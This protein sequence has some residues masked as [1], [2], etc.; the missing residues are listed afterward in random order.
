MVKIFLVGS[1]KIGVNKS[2]SD[3]DYQICVKDIANTHYLM[4]G[5]YKGKQADMHMYRF[6]NKVCLLKYLTENPTSFNV[7]C[8]IYKEF[9]DFWGISLHEALEIV[10]KELIRTYEWEYF[11]QQ[12][13]GKENKQK[14]KRLYNK[15]K[16]ELKKK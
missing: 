16:K 11:L 14:L 10:S 13:K 12:L 8:L 6:A 15:Y 3:Y 1:R 5:T 4:K 2:N 7:P 9:R